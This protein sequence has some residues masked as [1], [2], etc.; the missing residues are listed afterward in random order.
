MSSKENQ[1]LADTYQSKTAIEHILDAPDTYVGSIDEDEIH[2][3][4]FKTGEEKV[5][6]FNFRWVPALYKLFD[7][8]IVNAKDHVTRMSQ[9]IKKR[10]SD[11]GGNSIGVDGEMSAVT[12]IDVT[13][14]AETGIITIM[15][16]GNG[17]DV[18][19]HPEKD[20]WIPEMIFGHLRTS[21]NYKKSEKKIVGG[22]NGF[23]FKLVLIYSKWGKIE[24][25]DHT[26]GKKYVQE[27]RD[28]LSI[29][30]K[31]KITTSKKGKPYTKVSF[32]PDYERLGLEG[33]SEE[34]VNLFKRRTFDISA[35]TGK[36]VRV[37]FNGKA[38]SVKNFEQYVSLH[39]G[40]PRT[41]KR[42]YEAPH[43]R[44]EY[45]VALSPFDEYRQVSLVNG[46]YTAKGGK[47]VEYITNQIVRGVSQY[48]EKKKKV[49]VKASTI[50]EQLIVFVNSI[51]ENPSFDSQVKDFM[52]TPVSK[53]GSKCEVS[54]K[55]IEG[56]AKMGVMDTA[57]SLTNVKDQK[58]G[59]KTDG[60]KTVS[61]QGLP[62]L[63]D[64]NWAGTKNKS[65][66]CT[67]ILCEGDLAKA[68][69]MSGLTRKDR[70][71]I[72][73]F[74][75]K[76]KLMNVD[77]ISVTKLNSNDEIN[78]IKKIMGLKSGGKKFKTAEQLKASLRYG[79]IC[80][81]T[82]QDLDGTHI[83][84]LAINLFKNQW[85]ELFEMDNFLCYMNTP[86][87]KATKGKR[88]KSFY[89]DAEYQKWKQESNGGKG[90]KIKYYKGLGTSTAKEFR[91]YFKERK[92]I[93]FNFNDKEHSTESIDMVFGK[94]R[95]SDRK[96]WL[97]EYD[98]TRVPRIDQ[99]G[100]ASRLDYE[101]FVNGDMIHFS[102]YDCER[103]IANV[104]DG[105]KTSQRKI[106][107]ACFKRKL[108]KEIKVA[109]L[110]G[111]VSEHAAYHH[112]R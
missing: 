31:P 55:F 75:L 110:S 59:Q 23:G 93:Y 19:K 27:F 22:K 42:I 83:K 86:I 33:L 76:G 36:S 26:R 67:L 89:N 38:V 53:F 25:L 92:M 39:L 49:K 90:W 10:S 40:G 82:D 45:A 68:G 100:G 2:N 102:K 8:G 1:H 78:N 30:G 58:A 84:G 18:A 24:T 79:S 63:V 48:I 91:E 66:L 71:S 46:V 107:Y 6:Y 5:D 103:S 109:Q 57:I 98:K 77:E 16:N 96:Q 43:E 88:S 54:K 104:M 11:A 28:N 105:L 9:L 47:H 14:D 34:M 99:E 35:V 56:V 95:A 74:P 72:G 64:A 65:S 44:W 7:E 37:R 85:P 112:G 51:I 108:H 13:V 12:S 62:K 21:T 15:N 29:I 94:K 32:L 41:T 111:Y 52:T 20:M 81:M 70:D 60:K 106:L 87:L 69:I 3:W 4:N 97:S 61:I 50:K 101:E 73:V 80:F 17:I